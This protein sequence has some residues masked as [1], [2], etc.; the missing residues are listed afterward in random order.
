[1]TK[2]GGEFGFNEEETQHSQ[3]IKN[4]NIYRNEVAARH[5]RH[6]YADKF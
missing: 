5:T 6:N 1:M 3:K 4:R 2:R